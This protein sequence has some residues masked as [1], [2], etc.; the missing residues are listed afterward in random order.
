MADNTQK[1]APTPKHLTEYKVGLEK[2]AQTFQE[3]VNVCGEQAYAN[4]VHE[5]KL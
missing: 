5:I 4:L 2:A 1:P 3:M